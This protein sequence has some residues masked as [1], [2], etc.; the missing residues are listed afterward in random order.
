MTNLYIY[1]KVLNFT[2]KHK[3]NKIIIGA[4][5][6]KKLEPINDLTNTQSKTTIWSNLYCSMCPLKSHQTIANTNEIVQKVGFRG[7]VEYMHM[8]IWSDM[9]QTSTQAHTKRKKTHHKHK[10]RLSS[11]RWAAV[12][13]CGGWE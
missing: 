1:S 3:D 7:G 5:D 9:L 10:M 11:Y 6:T 2:E 8:H 13:G 12:S 4:G